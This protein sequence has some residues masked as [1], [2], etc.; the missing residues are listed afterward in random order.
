MIALE[1][2]RTI[3]LSP[4]VPLYTIRATLNGLE[5]VLRFDYSQ[6]EDRWFFSLYDSTGSPIR[7]GVKI[8]SGTSALR[9]ARY[10]DRTPK[11]VLMFADT[12]SS[13]VQA[14][15]FADLGR[16]VSLVYLEAVPATEAVSELVVE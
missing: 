8:T 12:A 5:Y 7:K 6:R 16:R 11:G 3:Q 14:P 13:S 4:D 10:D 1:A 2:P 15:G 9:L